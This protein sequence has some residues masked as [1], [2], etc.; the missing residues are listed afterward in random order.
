MES[1]EIIFSQYKETFEVILDC[2]KIGGE[3]INDYV[4]RKIR[5]ILHENIDFHSRRLVDEFPGDGVKFIPKLQS[6][7]ANIK[8][9]NKQ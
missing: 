7:C 5:N 3:D 9:E 1:L 8:E 2:P 6:H 4:K